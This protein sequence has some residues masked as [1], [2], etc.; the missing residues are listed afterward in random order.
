M[1]I[2]HCGFQVSDMTRAIEF[3][4]KKLGFKLLSL[5]TNESVREEYAF[6]ESGG[7]R[8][9]LIRD[10]DGDYKKP[11]LTKHLCPHA[12][13]ETDDLTRVIERLQLYDVEIIGGPHIVDGEE[14]WLYIKDDDNNVLEYI[15]W[16]HEK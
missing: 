3:Y 15:Q 6:L 12:C 16:L 8:V 14:T 10:L 13:L 5:N 11:E 4:T 2:D 1:G 7:A 9:E